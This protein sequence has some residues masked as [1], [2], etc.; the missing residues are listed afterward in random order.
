MKNLL[1][2]DYY[3]LLYRSHY[4]FGTKLT[5]SKGMEVNASHGFIKT[6]LKLRN[7][8]PDSD[9]V[10][11]TESGSNWRSEIYNS[12]KDG[13]KEM[14]NELRT[15]ITLINQFLEAYGVPVLKLVNYEADDII[16]ILSQKPYDKVIIVSS[17][18][19]LL[20]LVSDK[21]V[22]FDMMKNVFYNHEEVYKRYQLTPAQIVDYLSIVGDKSDNIPGAHGIG[23]KGALNLVVKYGSIF[24]IYE[25]INEI[26]GTMQKKLI[27][28]KDN[29]EL[30]YK[31]INL[32]FDYQVE[33]DFL[34]KQTN[35]HESK[36]ILLE[37]ELFQLANKII[38]N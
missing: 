5:N 27:D 33:I 23:E 7:D 11:A 28:S 10:C 19:D 4:G 16:A 35:L 9:I 32:L 8:Y 13:R 29:V 25:N 30:S 31:L 38:I 24:K 22:V 37:N 12:Y 14:P 3:N 20:Q 34:I 36:K 17:D 1:I 15:Q 6:I 18:K 26:T 21:V 2:I